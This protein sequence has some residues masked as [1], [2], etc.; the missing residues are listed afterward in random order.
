[1]AMSAHEAGRPA[2][3]GA[4]KANITLCFNVVLGMDDPKP[5][6]MRVQRERRHGA[7]DAVCRIKRLGTGQATHLLLDD[8]L[9]TSCSGSR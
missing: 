3:G 1:M 6:T 8:L 7:D 2:V 4:G 5:R 9:E